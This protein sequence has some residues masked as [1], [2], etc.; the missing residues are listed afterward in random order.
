IVGVRKVTTYIDHEDDPTLL[1][2]HE[3]S[4]A[5]GEPGAY[6]VEEKL[7]WALLNQP[8]VGEFVQVYQVRNGTVVDQTAPP[9]LDGTLGTIALYDRARGGY[10][11]SGTEL[12]ALGDDGSDNQR[13]SLSAGEANIQGWR[14]TRLDAFH[15]LEAEDP[16]LE[17]VAS[18]AINFT[19]AGTGT[20][21]LTVARPPIANIQSVSVTKRITENRVR[22][23]VPNG[24]DPLSQSSV[25]EI[26]SITE[27][28]TP[29]TDFEL[30]GNSVSWAPAG[31]EPANGETYSVTYLYF[32]AVT[33]DEFND[34]TVTVSGGVTDKTVLV[35]YQ[36]KIP[37]K[38]I[39]VFDI[40]GIPSFVKGVSARHGAL[41]PAAPEGHLKA[42]EIH[43]DWSGPPVVVN[44]GTRVATFDTMW[45]YFDLVLRS[46]EQL[47]RTVMQQS[48]PDSAAVAADGIF[49]DNFLNDDLRDGNEV[50]TAAANRGVLQLPVNEVQV[51]RFGG[52]ELLD[53]TEEVMISQPLA[54]GQMKINPYA[55]FNPMPGDLRINPNADRWT[56]TETVNVSPI[57]REFTAA[58]GQSPSTLPL[59][60]EVS[61]TSRAAEFLRQIDIAFTLAGFGVNEEL[62][63]LTFAG[64]DVTPAGPLVADANGEISGTF[65]IPPSIPVGQ[66]LV[67]ARGAADSFASAGF[68][69]AGVITTEVMRQVFLVTRSAPPPPQIINIINNI[70]NVT[71][72]TRTVTNSN[73]EASDPGGG[74]GDNDPLAA[75]FVP[76]RD[77]SHLGFN[78][79]VA[80]VG[81]P[82]NGVRAQLATTLNGYPTNEV[83]A[84][85]Y[86]SMTAAQPGDTLQIR[87]DS[88]VPLSAS[89]KYCVVLMTDDNEHA[90]KIAVLGDVVPE[91]QQRV[92]SQPYTAGDLFSG[93]NRTTW[94][95]HPDIDPKIDHI[96]AKFS[97]VQ[98][99]VLLWEGAIAGVTDLVVRGTVDLQ[100]VS[101]RFRYELERANGDVIKLAPGQPVEFDEVVSETVKV[102]AVLDG[103][104][105]QSPILWPNSMLI[106]GA[107]QAQGQYVSRV[108]KMQGAVAFRALFDQL[109]PPG[110][111]VEIAV[112]KVD[113]NWEV[114]NLDQTRPL[115]GGWNELL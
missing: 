71:N 43:N 9:A 94:I 115:S 109:A 40:N 14:R 41:P 93:S 56:T 66:H 13:F 74:P 25:I 31:D 108:F 101:T 100:S 52:L 59:N 37:R 3:N 2:P 8:G 57:T 4:D 19:D 111:S 28:G 92:A 102:R 75:T 80:A 6:R 35:S 24:L 32:D 82:N 15:L 10:I 88:P 30:S 104:E 38:D 110:S 86:I 67:Q 84:D 11:V 70:N 58:P 49:T 60:E 114:V 85:Q 87:W 78:V 81:N 26:E 98:K 89:E 33:V 65:T 79:E 5:E 83:L 12:T 106:C 17:T 91:T 55:N 99:T 16:D 107:V 64:R 1:G 21:I 18:E 42:A 62:A 105:Y 72:V 34:E 29:H 22:G 7:Q 54:T 27:G 96:I 73:W 44:N 50:Q 63:S 95:A 20:A 113:D 39:L 53:F 90:I 97:S 103:N 45:A 48:V 47:N 46:V 36:S 76:I 68:V 112:D 23:P 77:S 51:E 69:G 61:Q